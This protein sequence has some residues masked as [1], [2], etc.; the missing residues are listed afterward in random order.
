MLMKASSRSHFVY[1][2]THLL[3]TDVLC[4]YIDVLVVVAHEQAQALWVAIRSC[5]RQTHT[6]ARTG[7]IFL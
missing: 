5:S 2:N 4:I 7:L 1:A 3:P 6:H